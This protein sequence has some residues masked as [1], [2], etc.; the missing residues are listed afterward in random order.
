[1]NQVISELEELKSKVVEYRCLPNWETVLA[2]ALLSEVGLKYQTIKRQAYLQAQGLL[3][4]AQSTPDRQRAKEIEVI[5]QMYSKLYTELTEHE[6][7][8]Q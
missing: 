3:Y 1:M 8:L 2:D 7:I 6:N 4:Q 5:S